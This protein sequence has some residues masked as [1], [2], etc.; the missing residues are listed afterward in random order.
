MTVVAVVPIGG[1]DIARIEV[2]V[3]R[4]VRIASVERRRPVVA[5]RARVVEAA[6]I[7]VAG[8]GE[9]EATLPCGDREQASLWG[10]PSMEQKE[11]P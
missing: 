2:A 1:I 5:V 6:A 7:A 11:L 9:E 4:V 3:V 10:R 8:G